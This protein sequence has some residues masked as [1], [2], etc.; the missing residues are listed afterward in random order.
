[1][2]YQVY[3]YGISVPLQRYSFLVGLSAS[4]DM[5]PQEL[6]GLIQKIVQGCR[7]LDN[8]KEATTVR[9][10]NF[11][12]KLLKVAVSVCSRS[13]WLGLLSSAAV[14]PCLRTTKTEAIQ[15]HVRRNLA[16]K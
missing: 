13:C 8:S 4:L 3:T 1:M 9:Q 12:Q 14:P 10:M 16:T 11:S 2:R 7:A 5:M 6:T 15:I